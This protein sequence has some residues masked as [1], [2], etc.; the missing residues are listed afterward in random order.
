MATH[1]KEFSPD[2]MDKSAPESIF[3]TVYLL[4]ED[5]AS[6]CS[7]AELLSSVGIN[8]ESVPGSAAL[9]ACDLP[10]SP[11]CIL[12]DVR[13]REI[14]GLAV[15]AELSRR[16]DPIPI[17]FLTAYADV[18]MSV[19]A[20]KQGAFDFLTKPCRDQE[21]LDVVEAALHFSRKQLSARRSLAR[22]QSLYSTLT[23]RESQVI[24]Y[25]ARGLS[26]RQIASELQL[27]STTVKIY[28]SQISRKMEC[29]SIVDLVK[30]SLHLGLAEPTLAEYMFWS[31]FLQGEPM[32][33]T[34]HRQLMLYVR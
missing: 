22:L 28:R 25:V 9:L 26:N 18:T 23:R 13:L 27:S 3:G 30:V 12:L 31:R 34:L 24:S 4:D 29:R 20:M 14:S 8:V 33:P 11:S 16:G 15:Q 1:L 7:V 5:E 2:Q 6:R 17:I 21:L 19:G 32:G 10:D